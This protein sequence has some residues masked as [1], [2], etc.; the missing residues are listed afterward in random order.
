MEREREREESWAASSVQ[1]GIW[2]SGY[3]HTQSDAHT[4]M[5]ERQIEERGRGLCEREIGERRKGKCNSRLHV[6]VL[7][8][9]WACVGGNEGGCERER[10][11]EGDWG[12]RAEM[13]EILPGTECVNCCVWHDVGS[14]HRDAGK[15]NLKIKHRSS[16]DHQS[17]SR[18]GPTPLH[19]LL[20]TSPSN[21]GHFD[22]TLT[23]TIKHCGCWSVQK[24]SN[25][26]SQ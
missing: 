15:L 6:L 19:L 17:W 13:M 4:R 8:R 14:P 16:N 7:Q 20:C 2:S 3:T 23:I 9:G 18:G 11:R 25:S 21:H 5:H 26:L 10:E 22:K 12:K 24:S 1:M